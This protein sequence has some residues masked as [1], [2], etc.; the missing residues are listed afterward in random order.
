VRYAPA[1]ARTEASISIRV[2][3]AKTTGIAASRAGAERR[4]AR[5]TSTSAS[6]EVTGGSF[7]ALSQS[8]SAGLSGS[9]RISL[10][11]A[12]LSR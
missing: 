11:I 4:R 12:E 7:R 8:A 6:T 5:G 2:I 1:V 10:T 9:I 3:R